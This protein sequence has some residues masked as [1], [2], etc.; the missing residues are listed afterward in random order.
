MVSTTPYVD[1]QRCQGCGQCVDVCPEGAI[2]L[3]GDLAV[4][5]PQLCTACERCVG[6][7]PEQAVHVV[8]EVKAN[9]AEPLRLALQAQE[10]M[11][12]EL[13]PR[14]AALGVSWLF[15]SPALRAVAGFIGREVVPR[16]L[17]TLLTR[18]DRRGSQ[19]V[20]SSPPRRPGQ[21]RQ[22]RHRGHMRGPGGHGRRC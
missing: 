18:W 4:I 9:A 7:C 2:H 22:A 3:E 13:Q 17:D 15:R 10:P 5:D 1:P 19:P 16:A 12:A 11:S 20:A 14:Q 8:I 21:G 6:V